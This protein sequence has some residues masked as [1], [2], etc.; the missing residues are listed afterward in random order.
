MLQRLWSLT[1]DLFTSLMEDPM[2]TADREM[3]GLHARNRDR[4]IQAINERNALKQQFTQ[5]ESHVNALRAAYDLA[6]Q[7]GDTERALFLDR[8]R[9][10]RTPSG[11]G[12]RCIRSRRMP[13]SGNQK[14]DQ[15]GRG[16]DTRQARGGVPF[17]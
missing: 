3:K 13:L 17:Q 10:Q 11:V 16:K 7:N 4:A 9:E 6:Q 5:T 2:Q 15:G 14:R 8:D 1:R 12:S